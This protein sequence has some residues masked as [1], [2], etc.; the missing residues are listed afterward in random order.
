VTGEGRGRKSKGKC[1][2]GNRD[3]GGIVIGGKNVRER[4]AGHRCKTI[5]KCI[6]DSADGQSEKLKVGE[7]Y[8]QVRPSP[9]VVVFLSLAW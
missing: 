9:V 6:K 3:Q 2:R 8:I 4:T 1:V 7:R 5:P